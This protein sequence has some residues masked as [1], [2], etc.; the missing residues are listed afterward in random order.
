MEQLLRQ[1]RTAFQDLI[2][3]HFRSVTE[4][5]RKSDER[6]AQLQ[7]VVEGK[8]LRVQQLEQE[9]K[10]ARSELSKLSSLEETQRNRT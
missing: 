5:A 8:E 3:E 9:L 4:E 7:H 6:Q 2:Y 10:D 1:D